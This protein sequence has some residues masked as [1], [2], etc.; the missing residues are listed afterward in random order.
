MKYLFTNIL[1][2]LESIICSGRVYQVYLHISSKCV[3]FVCEN[4]MINGFLVQIHNTLL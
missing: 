1:I 2:L 3:Q 4:L